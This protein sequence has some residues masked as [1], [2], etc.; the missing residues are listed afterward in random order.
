VLQPS[1]DCVTLPEQLIELHGTTIGRAAAALLL[2]LPGTDY[3]NPNLGAAM[4]TEFLANAA[5][6]KVE[7]TKGQQNARLRTKGD[8]F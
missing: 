1:E 4:H 7:H 5:T 8:W 2:M 3:A 6:L